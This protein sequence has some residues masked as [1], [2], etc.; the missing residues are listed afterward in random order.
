MKSAPMIAPLTNAPTEDTFSL[1][2]SMIGAVLNLALPCIHLSLLN[3]S[4]SEIEGRSNLISETTN[5][6]AKLSIE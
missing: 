4:E 6:T 1:V 5:F 2:T 3:M